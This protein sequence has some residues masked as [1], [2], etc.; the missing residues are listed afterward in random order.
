MK[1]LNKISIQ[2]TV[3]YIFLVASAAFIIGSLC[4][5]SSSWTFLKAQKTVEY[6]SFW[7]TLTDLIR[8]SYRQ[9]NTKVIMNETFGSVDNVISGLLFPTTVTNMA[10]ITF[11]SN[12]EGVEYYRNLWFMIQNVNNLIFYTGCLMLVLTAICGITGC[13]SR[14]KYYISNLVSGVVT[15][16]IGIV[17]SIITIIMSSSLMSKLNYVKKDIDLYYE[18]EITEEDIMLR[19][20]QISDLEASIARRKNLLSNENYLNKAPKELVE[21]EKNTL[22]DE[23]EKLAKLKNE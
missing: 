14:R 18:K 1:F 22:K 13:F 12:A 6:E 20:K 7:K 16:G 10:S 2:K 19:N 5:V 8:V 15:G 11:A 9:P 4:F 17:L 3:F 21:K 23:E